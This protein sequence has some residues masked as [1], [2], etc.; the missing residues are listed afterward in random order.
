METEFNDAISKLKAVI[1]DIEVFEKRLKKLDEL[2][3]RAK[4]QGGETIGYDLARKEY[5]GQ[6]KKIVNDATPDIEALRKHEAKFDAEKERLENEK[7]KKAAMYEVE[8]ELNEDA[9]KISELEKEIQDTEGKIKVLENSLQSI[10]LIME[11]LQPYRLKPQS[12]C[13]H[14]RKRIVTPFADMRDLGRA[15]LYEC[16][17]C[18]KRWRE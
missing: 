2:A 5:E 14:P 1:S 3:E 7:L 13:S 10:H 17:D 18:G 12:E 9:T 16:P 11:K 15:V 8:R 4:A 6:I